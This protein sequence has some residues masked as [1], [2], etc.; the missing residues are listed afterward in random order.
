VPIGFDDDE[1]EEVEP[2]G[3]DDEMPPAV[4]E[5]PPGPPNPMV[6]IKQMSALFTLLGEYCP[7]VYVAVNGEK[8]GLHIRAAMP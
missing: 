5:A 8:D 1:R 7:A 2:E 4:E 6:I 3:G